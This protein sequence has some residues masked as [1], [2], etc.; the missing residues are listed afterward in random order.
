ME[1]LLAAAEAV[2]AERGI[3]NLTVHEVAR[4]AGV[5]AGTLYTRFANKDALLRALAVAFFDRARRTADALLEDPRWRTLPPGEK[6]EALVRMMVKSYR[7]KRGLLRAVHLY[8]RTHPDAAF[9]REAAASA[10][11]LAARL[12]RL[13]RHREIAPPPADR[14]ALVGFLVL[15][16][17]AR[18]TVLFADPH[19]GAGPSDDELIALLSDFYR[20]Q[21][22]LGW[23]TGRVR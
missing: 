18:E 10:H 22:G 14:A 9:Q 6:V 21:L 23:P 17:A 8:V 4:R 5:A 16:A 13:L 15:D 11:D 2:V 20:G 12:I 7:A 3:A 1:R 19:P